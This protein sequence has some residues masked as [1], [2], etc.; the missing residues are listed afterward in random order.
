MDIIPASTPPHIESARALFVEY[1]E[2]LGFSL[3]FQG[4]DEELAGLPGAYSPP[5]GRLLLAMAEGKPAGCVALRPKA[6]GACEVKRLFVRPAY[7]ASGLGRALM[8]RVLAE[9]REIGYRR[10]RLNTVV[11]Q[12]DRAIALYRQL[13]FREIEAY[14]EHPVEGTIWMEREL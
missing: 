4:F 1:A 12:M 14:D 7:R 5:E 9:A 10:M 8:N 11:G 13:G 6:D 2:S 3:C